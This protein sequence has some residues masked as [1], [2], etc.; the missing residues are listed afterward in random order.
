MRY[1]P[2][3]SGA[4]V[5][6]GEVF[7]KASAVSRKATLR[8]LERRLGAYEAPARE[9]A[10]RARAPAAHPREAQAPIAASRSWRGCTARLASAGFAT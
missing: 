5:Q 1:A 3:G 10:H 6:V 9:A 8:H 7:V 4:T 2:T